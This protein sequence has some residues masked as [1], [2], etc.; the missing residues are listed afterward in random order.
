MLDPVSALSCFLDF[1][2]SHEAVPSVT[3]AAAT[4]GAI[5]LALLVSGSLCT[6]TQLLI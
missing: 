5:C 4:L 2:A 6:H 3:A 1:L